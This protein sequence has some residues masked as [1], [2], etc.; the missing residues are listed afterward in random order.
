MCACSS[1]NMLHC[2]QCNS[3][4]TFSCGNKVTT[5]LTVHQYTSW[6]VVLTNMIMGIIR[7][8]IV[9]CCAFGLR[10]CRSSRHAVSLT[11][12]EAM[13]ID[14]NAGGAGEALN[15]PPDGS[16]SPPPKALHCASQNAQLLPLKLYSAVTAYN[17]HISYTKVLYNNAPPPSQLPP[18]T[19]IQ[20]CM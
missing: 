11:Q 4:R 17:L 14:Q 7:M 12:A 16:T 8:L 3:Y 9:T 6:V 13:A 5:H 19:K 1:L 15:S 10:V 2:K 20:L 18:Q